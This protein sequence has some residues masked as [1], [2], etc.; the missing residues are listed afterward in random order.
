MPTY[1]NENDALGG[2]GTIYDFTTTAVTGKNYK[3]IVV[4]DDAAFLVLTDSEGAD[5]LTLQGISTNTVTKGMVIRPILGRTIT[6]YTL[7]G[8]SIALVQ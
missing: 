1:G 4:N 8:G 6:A 5:M 7:S 3:F 2:A